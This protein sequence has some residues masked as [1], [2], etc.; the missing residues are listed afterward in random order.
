MLLRD[1][2]QDNNDMVSYFGRDSIDYRCHFPR[3]L[4]LSKFLLK[5]R[6]LMESD[7]GTTEES[8]LLFTR[9]NLATIFNLRHFKSSQFR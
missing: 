9:L 4:M 3:D 1:L 6:V 5:L 2:P 7:G 8:W